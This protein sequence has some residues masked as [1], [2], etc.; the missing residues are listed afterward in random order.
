MIE[1]KI[2]NVSTASSVENVGRE[3]SY[4]ENHVGKMQGGN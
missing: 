1:K 4:I 2:C 3:S